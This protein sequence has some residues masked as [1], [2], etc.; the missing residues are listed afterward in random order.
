[1]NAEAGWCSGPTTG[2]AIATAPSVRHHHCVA[3][4]IASEEYMAG[5]ELPADINVEQPR[6]RK[7]GRWLSRIL[8][9]AVASILAYTQLTIFVV[10][11]IGAVPEGRTLIMLRL[12]KTEFIDSADAMCERI[13]DGVSLLCRGA[14][15][16]A[17]V[18]N[19]TILVRLPYSETLYN[20][21][22]GGKSYSH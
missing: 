4:R 3:P 7:K 11:P 20:I 14:V 18:K 8:I 1:M 15:L 6:A 21:S 5:Q 16:G 12:N 10:Q 22:T 19:G 2:T 17:V 9:F 13:Q